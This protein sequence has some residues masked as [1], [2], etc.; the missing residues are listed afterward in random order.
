MQLHKWLL[1]VTCFLL[2]FWCHSR[3][4]CW[5]IMLLHTYVEF[6]HCRAS[7]AWKLS[8]CVSRRNSFHKEGLC[9][10]HS[11]EGCP[12]DHVR[13]LY[14]EFLFNKLWF[15][16]SVLVQW[17]AF[18]SLYARCQE[19]AKKSKLPYLNGSECRKLWNLTHFL[20][21]SFFLLSQNM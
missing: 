17:D 5:A 7:Y 2:K 13:N 9:C 15:Q 8:S 21:N 14:T 20:F 3:F 16:F 19:D 1:V 12:A 18:P 4:F 6:L 10:G 11:G